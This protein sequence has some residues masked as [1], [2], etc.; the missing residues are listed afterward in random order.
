VRER[1]ETKSIDNSKDRLTQSYNGS[2]WDTPECSCTC[3]CMSESDLHRLALG[4][5]TACIT[6]PVVDL[7]SSQPSVSHHTDLLGIVGIG[8][9]RVLQKP[10][11]HVLGCRLGQL[12]FL[13]VWEGIIERR[14]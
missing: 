11:S 12:E 14:S 8:M 4:D 5:S 9:G 3:A 7:R 1:E 6:E 13:L 2:I 10:I